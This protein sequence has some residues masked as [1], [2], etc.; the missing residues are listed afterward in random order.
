MYNLLS[1]TTARQAH[2][3]A[4]AALAKAQKFDGID[5]DY[6]NKPPKDK[7]IFF[8]FH[9]GAFEPFACGKKNTDLHDRTAF[10]RDG[11]LG[12]AARLRFLIRMTNGAQ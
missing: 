3:D 4:I 2:E 1:N 11:H 10:A 9:R 12:N 6:E 5:I 8:T 7:T